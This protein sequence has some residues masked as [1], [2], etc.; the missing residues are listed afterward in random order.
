MP[1]LRFLRPT[2]LALLATGLLCAGGPPPLPATPR[3]LKAPVR[4]ADLEAHLAA[5]ARP[6]LMTVTEVGRSAGQRPILLVRLCR[7]GDKARFRAL[8]VA[9]QHGN[10]VSGK[11]AL[12]FLIRDVVAQPE[13]LPEDLDLYILPTLNPDGNTSGKR[14]ND[15]RVDLNRDHLL[16][17]QPETQALYRVVRQIQPH[18]A[19]DGHEYNRDNADFSDKGLDRWPLITLD[20]LNHPLV[21]VALRTAGLEVIGA[22]EPPMAQAGFPFRRY[23]LGGPPPDEEVRPSTL[24]ADDARNGIGS[25][26][27]LAFIIEAGIR[28]RAAN[29]QGDLGLRVA[30]YLE[31]YRL[32]LGDAAFRARTLDL[33]EQAR[34]APLPPFLPV[35]YFWAN[36]GGKVL[37]LREVDRKSGQPTEIPTAN[38]MTDLVVKASVPTPAAYAIEPRAA[39]SIRPLLE[40]HGLAYRSLRAPE[41]HRVERCKLLRVEET[42]DELYQ[43]YEGRQVVTRGAA[44]TQELAAGTL[45]VDLRQPLAR[46]AIQ[47]LEPCLLY[48]L[49]GH[50]PFRKL[51]DPDG[52]LPVLRITSSQKD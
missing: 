31:L 16:L 7:G 39:E 10:E 21:P 18:L 4:Q 1:L 38:L 13:R 17:T 5:W 30:A 2:A 23:L 9:Q 36:A 15:A 48:G 8:L 12:L 46:R 27:A 29:P 50:A 37:S 6:G 11:D 43:R 47:L 40:R 14:T 33:V 28:R 51:V 24:E 19:V 44:S 35:N 22:A 34:T 49:Y 45:V 32:I 25:H 3:D 20:A 41:R 52:N 26:G 42:Y